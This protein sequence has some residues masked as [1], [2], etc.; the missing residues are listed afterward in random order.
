MSVTFPCYNEQEHYETLKFFCYQKNILGILIYHE[1]RHYSI[2]KNDQDEQTWTEINDQMVKNGCSYPIKQQTNLVVIEESQRREQE[3]FQSWKSSWN[4]FLS[5]KL[6]D[7]ISLWYKYSTF[8]FSF[9]FYKIKSILTKNRLSSFILDLFFKQLVQARKIIYIPFDWWKI[10]SEGFQ[11][12]T[13]ANEIFQNACSTR[14]ELIC[15]VLIN[16]NHWVAIK[17]DANQKGFYF[18]SNANDIPIQL[19]QAMSKLGIK[20]IVKVNTEPQTNIW[21]CGFRVLLWSMESTINPKDH[22][23]QQWINTT[24]I[25]N[26]EKSLKSLDSMENN[27]KQTLSDWKSIPKTTPMKKDAIEKVVKPHA[28]SVKTLKTPNSKS[29]KRKRVEEEIQKVE[30]ELQSKRP[31]TE[32]QVMDIEMLDSD[33]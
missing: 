24:F 8:H 30:V 6:T 32:S 20:N 33:A 1:S 28:N 25:T 21:E 5:N 26:I 11:L 15:P 10:T 17:I 18:D 14:T 29:L 3:I 19:E 27:W 2:F 22:E 16:N 4:S 13:H 12:Q 7:F 23:L 9:S 31:K